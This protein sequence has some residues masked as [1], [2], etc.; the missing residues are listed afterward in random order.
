MSD[1]NNV[2]IT[3]SIGIYV[4]GETISLT[5][6]AKRYPG[7][8]LEF[9]HPEPVE[10]KCIHCKITLSDG[11]IECRECLRENKLK[12]I[13][14]RNISKAVMKDRSFLN[15]ICTENFIYDYA[16][17]DLLPSCT[18]CDLDLEDEVLHESARKNFFAEM[19][20]KRQ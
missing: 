9:K 16:H 12:R 17:Q 4:N 14:R 1:Y 6:F 5:E 15:Y 18:C 13:V 8:K 7:A 20:A 11:D 2:T 10:S 3:G 19:K